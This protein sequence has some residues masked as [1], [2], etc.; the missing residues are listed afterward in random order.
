MYDKLTLDR[1]A[2]A[3]PVLR[4]ELKTLYQQCN[5]RLGKGIRIRF[6]ALFRSAEEQQALY[7]Q[8]RTTP[9]PVVTNAK[10]YESFHNYGLAFDFVLLYDKDG[11]DNFEEVSW[12]IFHDQDK[13]GKSDW[14]EVIG[15]F[16]SKGYVWGGD[17]KGFKDYPHFEKTFG[18]TWQQLSTLKKDE[19]GYV[20]F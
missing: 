10:P 11:D 8:G 5:V 17:F 12:D 14:M 6:T 3:H 16:K 13:N 4:D 18:F 7:N 20:V 2:L 15:F 19:Y 1:I 9:G